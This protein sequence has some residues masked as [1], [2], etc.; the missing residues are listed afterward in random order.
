MI[1][2]QNYITK[3]IDS[4][5][6]QYGKG[7]ISNVVVTG[8]GIEFKQTITC[9][10]PVKKLAK[11]TLSFHDNLVWHHIR[12]FGHCKSFPWFSPTGKK[13]SCFTADD[14]VRENDIT[15]GDYHTELVNCPLWWH[16]KGWQQTES[17]YGRKLVSPYKIWY[18]G[19]LY[20]L[21]TICFSNCGSTYF[22]V[23]GRKIFVS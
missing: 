7:S 22:T 18:E 16:K 11:H 3:V 10:R 19:K 4:L 15:L 17:G 5:N 12:C 9:G 23:N 8:A 14:I 2:I 21:Y 20:R 1:T 13:F 6:T